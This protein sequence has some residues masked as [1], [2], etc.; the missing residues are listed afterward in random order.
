M[1]V[2]IELISKYRSQ[3]MGVAT[4]WVM[5]SHVRIPA[6]GEGSF[7]DFFEYIGFGGVEMFMLVSGFGLFFA[8]QKSKSMKEYYY[9]RFIRIVPIWL[10]S[11]VLL[12]YLCNTYP[13]FSLE[14][15]RRIGQCW[16]FVPFIILAYVISPYIYKVICT[17]SYWSLFLFIG[18]VILIQI[19][20]KVS[21]L[22][23]IMITL[24]FARIFDFMIGMWFAQMMEEGK[25]L[26]AAA[27]IITGVIGF[28]VVYL[29]AKNI[30]W[31]DF[32][33]NNLDLRLY[34]MIMIGPLMCFIAIA[35]SKAS[36]YLS[37]CLRW[38]GEMSFEVYLVHVLIWWIVRK[39]DLLPWYYFYPISIAAAYLMHIVN[40]H[41][42]QFLLRFNV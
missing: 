14:W 31:K 41:I 37:T 15:V 11:I 22:S 2:S 36:K 16:W 18:S 26:N 3:I 28:I 29:C 23:N 21:G 35:I 10:I 1:N 27:I 7:L 20:Y 12:F 9:R 6:N 13:F 4:L 5:T 42:S 32:W 8:L 30:I 24:S 25:K 38:V 40:K 17:K 19:A 39:N 34:F 33:S